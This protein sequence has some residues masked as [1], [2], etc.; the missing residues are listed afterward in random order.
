MDN[1]EGHATAISDDPSAGLGDN[2]DLAGPYGGHH[3]VPSPPDP[4]IYRS[5]DLR[6]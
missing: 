6:R 2:Y 4:A 5:Q 1:Q 3:G